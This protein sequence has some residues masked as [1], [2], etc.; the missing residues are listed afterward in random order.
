MDTGLVKFRRSSKFQELRGL[1]GG[2]FAVFLRRM[3]FGSR[4]LDNVV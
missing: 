4:T 1:R 3:L 2:I